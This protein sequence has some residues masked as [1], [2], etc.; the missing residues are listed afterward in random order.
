M[1]GET[2]GAVLAGGRSRRLGGKSKPLL[3]W[4]G[5]VLLSHALG[6]VRAVLPRVLVISS[7]P[8]LDGYGERVPDR[9][10]GAGPLGGIHAALSA[11]AG[12]YCFVLACDMPLVPP[13]LVALLVRQAQPP[14]VA[15]VPRVGPHW[16]PLCAVYSTCLAARAAA[17]VSRGIR[18][19][20]ALF[21]GL[22]V[23]AVEEPTLCQFGA[24]ERLF[25]NINTRE[26]YRRARALV[27]EA[28]P[29]D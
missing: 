26:D 10:V 2:Y 29:G 13:E 19:V 6:V 23:R 5:G 21:D 18:K 8:S 15:V 7:D 16:E 27:Q 12:Q 24:P 11:G 25:L 4:G 17:L 9:W 28:S 3:R 20:T 22:P 1:I 14:Y